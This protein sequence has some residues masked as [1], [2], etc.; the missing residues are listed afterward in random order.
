MQLENISLQSV[1]DEGSKYMDWS[2]LIYSF[3]SSKI[4]M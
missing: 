4:G 2:S 1:P 3:S